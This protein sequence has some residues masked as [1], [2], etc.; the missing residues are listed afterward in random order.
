MMLHSVCRPAPRFTGNLCN[1]AT[2]PAACPHPAADT[3]PR[4]DLLTGSTVSRSTRHPLNLPP[5]LAEGEREGSAAL[6]AGSP[7]TS[8]PPPAEAEAAAQGQAVGDQQPLAAQ[9]QQAQQEGEGAALLVRHEV[10]RVTASNLDMSR[11]LR[12]ADLLA[13]YHASVVPRP[14]QVRRAGWASAVHWSRGGGC[15][16][17]PPPDASWVPAPCARL[18]RPGVDSG[19]LPAADAPALPLFGLFPPPLTAQGSNPPPAPAPMHCS[20]APPIA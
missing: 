6:S 15:S 8:L 2:G 13:V 18:C 10:V 5:T 3:P 20:R 11:P 4:A 14:G 7:A 19:R 16:A 17:V 12:S 1:A 9:H